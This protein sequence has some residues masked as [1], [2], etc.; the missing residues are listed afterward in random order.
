MKFKFSK[1]FLITLICAVVAICATTGGTLAYLFA[2][3]EEANNSFTPVFVSCKVEEEFDGVTKSNVK[4]RNTGDIS[5]YI[6][7]TTVIT[8]TSESG[9][10]H[11]RTP[12]EGVDYVIASGSHNW[13]Q[14]SDGFYYYLYPVASG[15]TTDLLFGSIKEA[16]EAPEGYSLTVHIIA[17]AIQSEPANAV[18]EAWGTTVQSGGAITPP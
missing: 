15:A 3:T 4:V 5:A 7:A 9:S 1:K 16:S 2:K 8:W 14:G 6:R 10:V 12:V 13:V 11:S 17:S 18:S